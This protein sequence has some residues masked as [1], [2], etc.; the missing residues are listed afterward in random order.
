M[1]KFFI[2]LLAVFSL[3]SFSAGCVRSNSWSQKIWQD[4]KV[5]DL[6]SRQQLSE[7]KSMTA[8]LNI[9]VFQI[10]TDKLTEIQAL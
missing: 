7:N 2:Y 6:I 3:I 9:Y 8:G 4:V 10:L 5:T 1:K